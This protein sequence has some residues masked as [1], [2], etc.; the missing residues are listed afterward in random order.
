MIAPLKTELA[1][2]KTALKQMFE[3]VEVLAAQ[4][5]ASPAEPKPHPFAKKA[6]PE[7][8]SKLALA[9]SKLNHNN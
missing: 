5:A 9:L 8:A 6:D 3:V 7:M 1:A 4:P 2:N